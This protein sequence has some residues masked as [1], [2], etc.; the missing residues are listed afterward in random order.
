M[1]EVTRLKGVLFT[2][3]AHVLRVMN[4]V[5]D[6]F[7]IDTEVCLESTSALNAVTTM[8]LDTLILDWIGT[9]E[10]TRI[11]TAMRSCEQ[12][13]KSTVLA[14]VKGDREMQAATQAGA[15]FIVYKPMDVDQAT[16]FVRA[17][18][19]NMLLQRRRA[20]RV[21]VDIPVVA[22]VL[23][24][25][26]VEGRII[27]LSVRGL[28][29]LCNEE[30]KVGQELAIAFTL[31][32]IAAL[33]HVTGKVMNVIKA[34]GLTRVGVGFSFVPQNESDVLEQ[35]ILDHPP[36]VPKQSAGFSNGKSRN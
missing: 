20:A 6:N 12:N 33:V 29:F 17:A 26:Q 4:Q 9:Y 22:N 32:G 2:T 10:S 1:G 11:L 30:I 28:A 24:K 3:D 31:A 5:L 25:G 18:Y 13:A 19:G 16:R 23:E 34:D 21:A 27:N 8:K 14:M 7:E 15:N 36:E 35:W